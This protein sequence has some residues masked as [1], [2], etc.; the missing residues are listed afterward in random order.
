[1]VQGMVHKQGVSKPYPG[2]PLPTGGLREQPHF[3]L[4]VQMRSCLQS[5]M[6]QGRHNAR[7]KE[8]PEHG[9]RWESMV[10][11]IPGRSFPEEED[12]SQGHG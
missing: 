8:L 9:R 6:L 4:A 12:Q 3:T 1:M 2:M 10:S 11:D 7:A 5:P